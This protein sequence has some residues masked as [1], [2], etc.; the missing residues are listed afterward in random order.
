MLWQP[1]VENYAGQRGEGP[2]L[3][4]AVREKPLLRIQ[5]VTYDFFD[6]TLNP[7]LDALYLHIR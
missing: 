3:S 6:L 7:R 4:V 1:H 2:G 5:V